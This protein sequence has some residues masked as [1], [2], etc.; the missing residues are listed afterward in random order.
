MTIDVPYVSV[1]SIGDIYG[2]NFNVRRVY[3]GVPF[4]YGD[5][6]TF[7][8]PEDYHIDWDIKKAY[9]IDG[10]VDAYVGFTQ[11]FEFEDIIGPQTQI[12]SLETATDILE[13]FLA[14][15]MKIEVYDVSFMY[16]TIEEVSTMNR[17]VYPCWVYTGHNNSDG[18]NI[19]CA[20]DSIN[21]EVFY[22]TYLDQ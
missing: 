12:I 13:E 10:N 7:Q 21:G 2:Y 19:R 22:Y 5:F 1:F 9:T 4:L 11:G 17:T 20:V 6:G 8:A 18:R 15:Q 3:K 14:K 16:V